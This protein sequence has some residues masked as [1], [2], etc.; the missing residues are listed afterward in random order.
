MK[1]EPLS[2]ADHTNADDST[3]VNGL[4][5]SLIAHVALFLLLIIKLTFFQAKSIDLSQA[6]RVD[7][8]GLPEK[9]ELKDLPEKDQQTLKETKP[10]QVNEAPKEAPAEPTTQKTKPEP[11]KTAESLNLKKVK[12]K[13]KQALD[14]IKKMSAIEKIKQDVLA[15]T[16]NKSGKVKGAVISAGSAL[17]GLDKIQS[18]EYLIKLDQHIKNNWALPQWMIGKPFKTQILVK[19]SPDGKIIS[20]K[21]IKPSGNPAYDDFCLAAIEQSSPLPRVPEKFTEK[22][23][24]DGV[25]I[26]FPE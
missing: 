3:E 15:Q 10:E 21:V 14:K 9:M 20:S 1:T 23:S 5:I 11:K 13:Q 22:Y 24:V 4:L 2:K 16:K 25:V 19:F 6:I 26:G 7:M 17:T 12:N 8:V 18:D